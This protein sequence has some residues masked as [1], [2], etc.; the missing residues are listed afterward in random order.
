MNHTYDRDLIDAKFLAVHERFSM[1]DKAL[2][3]ILGQVTYT[4]GKVRKMQQILLIVGTTVGVLLVTNGSE[5][6]QFFLQVI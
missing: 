6:I 4:N 2:G 5:L 3:Q 1:Q